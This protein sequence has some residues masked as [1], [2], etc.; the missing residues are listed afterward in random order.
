[1]TSDEITSVKGD[2]QQ[3]GLLPSGLSDLLHPQAAQDMLATRNVMACFSDFGYVQV[4]P[5]L[6]EFE[7]TLIGDGPGASLAKSSFRLLDPVSHR[8]MALRADMTAQVARISGTRLAHVPRPLRLAYSGEVM[9]V[10]P[11]VLNPERQLVQAGA[12]IIGRDDE[13]AAAEMVVLGVRALVR[14]GISGLTVDLGAPRLAELLLDPVDE[15]ARNFLAEAVRNRDTTSLYAHGSDIGAHLA[16]LC[17]AS[18]ESVEALAAVSKNLPQHASDYLSVLLS[19]ANTLSGLKVD[20]SITLDPLDSQGF[21]YHTSISFSIFGQGLRGAIA[22]GGAYV[23]GYNEPAVGI[24]IYMDRLLRGL[25]IP[26]ILPRLYI[27]AEAGLSAGLSFADRGRQVVFGSAG[28][29]A[30]DEARALD[31]QLILR[32]PDGSPEEL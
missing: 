3:Q 27:S 8:M 17:E 16:D 15:T 7:E 4:K 20:V 26:D 12:E 23:T 19:V 9:R 32:T 25:D 13:Q 30:D 11:D 2:T 21:D 22:R 1:M 10:V 18:G 14:A 5:P 31:C 6:V 28:V 24:S 29:N